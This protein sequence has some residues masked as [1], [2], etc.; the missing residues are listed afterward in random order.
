MT[1]NSF[2]DIILPIAVRGRFTYRIPDD[3]QGI[4]KPGV[5]VTVPLGS[6]NLYSG[7]VWKIH[8]RQP[9]V[10][11]L[12]N[13]LTVPDLVPAINETQLK[14]WLWISEY[15]LCSEGEVMKAAL[16]SETS[17]SNYK[18]RYE[19]FIELSREYTD[20]ELNDILDKLGKAPRQ[21]ELLLSYISLTGYAE[22]SVIRP[23][24][25]PALLTRARSSHAIAETLIGKGILKAISSEVSRLNRSE[26]FKEPVRELSDSQLT[27]FHSI[28][29]H[30]VY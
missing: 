30:P 19:T 22:G 15:Y 6:K 7:I 2:A 5:W 9:D 25:K 23:V 11:K 12:R 18:P 4:I 8:D 3:L 13:I 16:P 14:F 17:L 21:Q 10:I 26:S 1:N 24:G 29:K 27:A 20:K 28:K